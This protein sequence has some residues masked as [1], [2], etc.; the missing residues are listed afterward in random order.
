MRTLEVPKRE[1]WRP[2]QAKVN[3]HN[4]FLLELYDK[5]TG[6]KQA[7]AEAENVVTNAGRTYCADQ[8]YFP[9]QSVM[10]Q[11][12]LGTGTGAPSPTDTSMGSNVKASATPALTTQTPSPISWST[13]LGDWWHR[14]KFYFSELIANFSL[15]EVGLGPSQSNTRGQNFNQSTWNSSIQLATRAL[16]RD[17][18]GDPISVT[19]NN[20]QIM[21]ITATVYLTR[22]GVDSNMRLL[23]SFFARNVEA[24]GTDATTNSTL[25]GPYGDWYL[26]NGTAT[27]N[28]SDQ[29]LSGTQLAHKND[30]SGNSFNSRN[31]VYWTSVGWWYPGVTVPGVQRPSEKPY[32]SAYSQDWDTQEGNVTFSEV[33]FRQVQQSQ[34]TG[35]NSQSAIK[36]VFPCG[37]ITGTSATK[38]NTQKMRQYLEIL[39]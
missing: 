12:W 23:D 24:S 35:G 8:G 3:L 13:T 19:K 38:T 2:P 10:G 32:V 4:H 37:S 39:W 11:I 14:R 28:N 1:L 20:T 33:L 30:T 6:Q 25:V 9:H 34:T 17:A 36:L 29:N 21:V 27:P 26:G 18:N 31:R 5:K 7:E 22:G 16:F 15:T